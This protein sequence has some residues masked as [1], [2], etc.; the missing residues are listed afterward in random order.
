MAARYATAAEVTGAT[1]VAPALSVLDPALVTAWMARAELFVGIT[2]W[3]DR[4]S[5]GHALISAHLL[6]LTDAAIA[7]GV[8]LVDGLIASESHGPASRS[9]VVPA[10]ASEDAAFAGTSYGK[11]FAELRRIV[12][13]SMVGLPARGS[14]SAAF[15]PRAWGRGGPVWS[16]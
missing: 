2:E 5:V 3:G 13:G 12:V 1:G 11:L 6:S 15:W 8:G 4:A 9:F 16:R 14:T 7:A 10:P